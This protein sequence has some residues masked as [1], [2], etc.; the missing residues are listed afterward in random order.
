MLTN[1]KYCGNVLVIKT[2]TTFFA[3]LNTSYEFWKVA[4]RMRSL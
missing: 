3:I 4:F 2:Y 1:E